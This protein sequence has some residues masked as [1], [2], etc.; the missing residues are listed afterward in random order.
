MTYAPEQNTTHLER[1]R[2]KLLGQ[3]RNK[4]KIRALLDSWIRPAQRREDT[5]YEVA[6]ALNLEAGFGAILDSIGAL[7]QRGRE[8]LSDELYKVALRAKIRVNRSQG[9][10]TDLLAVANLALTGSW[11]V[12]DFPPA[13]AVIVYEDGLDPGEID[14]LLSIL[15]EVRPLG[16]RIDLLAAFCPPA[17][18]LRLGWSGDP[19]LGSPGLGWS[20]DPTL[21]GKLAHQTRLR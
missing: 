8:G 19:A 5:A 16:I 18:Q 10:L 9:K 3:F 7:V 12:L 15:A 1:A 20:G 14:P 4:P 21:G 17:E 13:S 2:E 6:F 11:Y